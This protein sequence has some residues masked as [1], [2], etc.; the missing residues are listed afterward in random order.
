MSEIKVG[1]IGL[2]FMGKTHLAAFGA[3]TSQCRV[4]AVADAN[5]D[6]A[7]LATAGN[8]ASTGSV[9]LTGIRTYTT[10]QQLLSDA[11]IDLVSVCTPTDT[12]RDLALAAIA[13]GKHLLLE[14][15]VAVA[16]ADVRLVAAAVRPGLVAMPAMVMRFWPGWPW[17]RER[18]HE[19]RAGKGDFGRLVGVTFQRL[20]SAPAWNPDF[21][22]SEARTGGAL[23]DLHIHD[24]DFILWC[25][26]PPARTSSVG[27]LNHVT[28]QYVYRD[29]PD[30]IV[31][32]GGWGHSPGFPFVMRYVAVFEKATAMFDL[33]GGAAPVTVFRDGVLSQPALPTLSSYQLEIDHMLDAVAAARSGAPFELRAT[34][35]DAVAVAELLEGE[36]ASLTAR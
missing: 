35:Q 7:S 17:L 9:D 6:K 33:S 19:A 5:I 26:G 31:A 15:P 2:G 12:H 11:D 30:H 10:A 4:V 29:G 25:F 14:K 23:T 8:L 20:G 21:Y 18:I 34:M 27:S 3:R 36:R 28:T 13:A 1:I 32:Q 24:S 16:S 22:A